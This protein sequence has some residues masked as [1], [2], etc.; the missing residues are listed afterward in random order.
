MKTI[1]NYCEK[2][3]PVIYLRYFKN[4]L[5]Y[6]GETKNSY[7]GRPFRIMEH[8]PVDRIRLLKCSKNLERRHYWEAVL[9]CK[10][11]PKK[12]NSQLYVKKLGNFH[13]EKIKQKRIKRIHKR[14]YDVVKKLV[15]KEEEFKVVEQKFKVV[16][17][18]FKKLYQ[19]SCLYK[20]VKQRLVNN[21]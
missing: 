6:V 7:G 10:L 5:M 15:T 14:Y 11:K 20:K 8:N 16:E 2:Q 1:V 19:K 13:P 17:Q 12:Q 21:K 18:E 4:E 9:I 3:Y